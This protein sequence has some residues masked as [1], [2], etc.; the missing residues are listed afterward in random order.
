MFLEIFTVFLPCWEVL[1]A[2]NLRQET[3]DSIA[4]WE[5]N[6][7]MSGSSAKSLN[8]AN[9]A[10]ESFMTGRRS[11]G[12]A[13]SSDSD[14]SILTMSALEYVLER[15]PTPLQEFSALRDFSGENIAFLTCVVEWEASLPESVRNGAA[16]DASQELVR[17]RFNRA[18]RIYAEYISVKDA[19]FPINIGSHE[20]KKL[21]AVFEGPA[22]IL[23]GEKREVD[24]ATPFDRLGFEDT[25]SSSELD[26]ADGAIEDRVQFW[27]SIPAGFGVGVFDE[28]EKH[29]KYLVLTN[30]WP[31][32]VKDRR[33]SMDDE[34]EAGK[35]ILHMIRRRKDS[36]VKQ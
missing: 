2:S 35:S 29:V 5:V 18:L 13:K 12:S 16:D 1:R 19:E 24:A 33:T 26:K 17:E 32:F 11:T 3:L 7:K 4:Q 9:T 27:G 20:L 10:V 6:N 34:V 28:S 8:S 23:Y 14:E 15:N 25:P 36:S 21:E 30:T 22:R 31:K